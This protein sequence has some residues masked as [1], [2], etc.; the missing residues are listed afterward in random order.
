M[1]KILI[2]ISLILITFSSIA[3][4]TNEPGKASVKNYNLIKIG[5]SAQIDVYYFGGRDYAYYY[6]GYEYYYYPDGPNAMLYLAYEHIW[7]FPNKLAVALEPKIGISFREYANHFMIGNDT[8]FY[9]ANK[10]FWR[11]GM[12]FSTDYILGSRDTYRYIQ[13]DNGNYYQMK[14]ITMYYQI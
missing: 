9:W 6:D 8:K 4:E 12:A 10:D 14:Q 11:M 13:M 2:V 5:S 3:Q 7:E 1:K